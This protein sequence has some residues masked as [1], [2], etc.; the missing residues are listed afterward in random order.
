M[1][2]PPSEM[3]CGCW[4]TATRA[5]WPAARQ[6]TGARTLWN[7]RRSDARAVV[8]LLTLAE[9]RAVREPGGELDRAAQQ[10]VT[11]RARRLVE[12]QA[13]DRQ[14]AAARRRHEPRGAA[15]GA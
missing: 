1:R 2:R 14:P 6:V 7:W 9:P 15:A 4:A 13:G 12:H 5:C 3:S 11:A 8:T 10:R